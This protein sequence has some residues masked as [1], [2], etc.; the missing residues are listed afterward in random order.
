MA[1]KVVAGGVGGFQAAGLLVGDVEVEG[2]DGV[3]S[4]QL[5]VFD[6]WEH[7]YH[8]QHRRIRGWLVDMVQRRS[9]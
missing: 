9:S 2:G 7:A 5:L 3:F 1:W 6:A 4:V 8:L